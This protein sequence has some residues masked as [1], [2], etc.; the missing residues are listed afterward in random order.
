MDNQISAEAQAAHERQHAKGVAAWQRR[1]ELQ[2]AVAQLLMLADKT[3]KLAED[4]NEHALAI[5]SQKLSRRM[6]M[7]FRE[8]AQILDCSL[9]KPSVGTRKGAEDEAL[10][11]YEAALG[12]EIQVAEI[13]GYRDDRSVDVRLDRPIRVR[14]TQSSFQHDVLHWNDD[15]LD[16]IWNVELVDRPRELEGLSNFWVFGPSY[17]VVTPRIQTPTLTGP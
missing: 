4:A 15:F 14:V 11:D 7:A 9:E 10:A 6:Q 12:T 2:G 8:Q 3:A 17:R 5:E 1:S 13:T 16:P